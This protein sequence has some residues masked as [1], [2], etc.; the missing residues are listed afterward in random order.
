MSQRLEQPVETEGGDLTFFCLAEVCLDQRA[1]PIGR[2]LDRLRL[3]CRGTQAAEDGG[4][5]PVETIKIA[6]VL[7]K[8]GPAKKIEILD[9]L[10]REIE[11]HRRH[12][13]EIFTQRNRHFRGAQ[14]DKK[15]DEH[16]SILPGA[17]RPVTPLPW[18]TA[19]LDADHGRAGGER[20]Q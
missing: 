7:D 15:I 13:G 1:Q 5:D 11:F 3:I 14:R 12:Q 17:A 9:R 8:N 10:H 2:H 4:K 19:P 6:L 20:L 16:R 18:R